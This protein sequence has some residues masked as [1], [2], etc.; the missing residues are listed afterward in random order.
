M[1]QSATVFNQ[2]ITNFN[3]GNVAFMN[4]M[5]QQAVAFNNGEPAGSS[6]RPLNNWDTSNVREFYG[7][8]DNAVSFN[9]DVGEWDVTSAVKFEWMF[10]QNGGVMRFDRDI[11][12]WCVE[13]VTNPLRISA[14]N[15]GGSIRAEYLPKWGEPCGARVILTDSDG[16]NKLTDTETA[17]ITATFDR[18]MNNSPQYSLNGGAYS[19]LTPTGDPKIWTFLLDPTSLTPDQYTFTVTGTCVIGGYSYDP[20]AG[21]LDGD[22]T[23]VD[24]ITFTIEK[25]PDITFED[26]IVRTYGDVALTL[27]H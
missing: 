7:T 21:T 17:I 5:F 24:S 4:G 1:F 18:D 11:S 27:R 26:P 20:L 10:R 16:D 8:F 9:Q 23:G 6:G 2:N 3:V 14:F 19:N 13:H 15:N 12:T 22:E 25:T